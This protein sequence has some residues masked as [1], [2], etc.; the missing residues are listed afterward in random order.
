VHPKPHPTAEVTASFRLG[1]RD[2]NLHGVR[3][4]RGVA[5]A[6][7]SFIHPLPCAAEQ[8]AEVE[9]FARFDAA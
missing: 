5:L 1:N 2:T 3:A 7:G 6:S 8:S 9:S 4:S